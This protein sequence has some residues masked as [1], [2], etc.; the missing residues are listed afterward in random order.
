MYNTDYLYVGIRFLH[1]FIVV[2][3]LGGLP[4]GSA[5][6]LVCC[7][8]GS[9]SLPTLNAIFRMCASRLSFGLFSDGS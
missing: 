5:R 9:H 4:L 8:N 7:D 1:G 2:S 6:S 3:L